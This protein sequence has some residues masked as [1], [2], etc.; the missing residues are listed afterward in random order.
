MTDP[1]VHQEPPTDDPAH[2]G[3]CES[4]FI[5]GPM[6]YSPCGCAERRR[7]ALL[8]QLAERGLWVM[9]PRPAIDLGAVPY[10]PATN[11][12]TALFAADDLQIYK[13]PLTDAPEEH[14][15]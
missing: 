10:D 14:Q 3:Q 9:E 15:P 11:Q 7:A 1:F 12:Y 4:E 2:D 8:D 5:Y 6:A 13:H